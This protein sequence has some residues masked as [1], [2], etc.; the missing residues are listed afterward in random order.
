MKEIKELSEQRD[1]PYSWV[2]RLDIVKMS[3]LPNLTCNSSQTPS[4]LFCEY[5]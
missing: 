4:E 1:G 2:G 3:A 5:Q